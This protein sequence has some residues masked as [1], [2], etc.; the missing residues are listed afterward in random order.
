MQSSSTFIW[1][2]GPISE[3]KRYTLINYYENIFAYSEE[4]EQSEV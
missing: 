3:V 4:S 1:I 2:S